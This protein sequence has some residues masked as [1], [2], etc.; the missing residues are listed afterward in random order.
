MPSLSHGDRRTY[1]TLLLAGKIDPS[2]S[3]WSSTSRKIEFVL[4]KAPP[5]L[6]WSTWGKEQI[7]KVDSSDNST[8]APVKPSM[9]HEAPPRSETATSAGL[10]PPASG[11]AYP[12]S[13]KGGPRNWD[14]LE[15]DDDMD[16]AN[17]DV[18]HF[19]K[20]LYAGAS[21]EQRRAMMK[22]FTESNGTSLSTDW[23]DVKDRTVTVEPPEGVEAKKWGD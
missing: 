3:R 19:F 16:E 13:S 23:N 20:N 10:P 6:K 1:S 15:Q 8:P 14:K 22:S 18:D 4:Q 12:T 7:G 17:H 5:G 9:G 2:A 11:P 21:E